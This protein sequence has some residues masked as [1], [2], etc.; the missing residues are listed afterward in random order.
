MRVMTCLPRFARALGDTLVQ[1]SLW[2]VACVSALYAWISLALLGRLDG[3]GLAGATLFLF[4]IYTLDRYR[5]PSEDRREAPV[6][7]D[8]TAFV[9]R[10]RAAFR[11]ALLLS[12]LGLGALI[13]HRPWMLWSLLASFAVTA[14]YVI[15]IPRRGLRL[16]DLPF[17]KNAY[18]PL[19][20]VLFPM[21]FL[22]CW[23]TTERSIAVFLGAALL[24]QLNIW[25]FDVKDI[26]ADRTTGIKL[27]STVLPT[28]AYLSIL[29][30]E[31]LLLAGLFAWLVPAPWNLGA[32][33]AALGSGISLW[34]LRR[35]FSLRWLFVVHEAT[36]ALPLLI[37]LLIRGMSP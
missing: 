26:S 31:S 18:A 10:H 19:S 29:L 9:G 34:H 5:A 35:S 4:I 25:T 8:P 24:C 37:H 12:V 15:P 14:F 30:T 28:P 23:P 11:V 16:K 1:S 33:G 6:E 3:I 13:L 7:L 2:T 21:V 17:F 20:A 32:A 27:L 22:N 36:V